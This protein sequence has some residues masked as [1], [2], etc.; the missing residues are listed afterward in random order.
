M[1]TFES[2]Y[3]SIGILLVPVPVTGIKLTFCIQ[4]MHK[5]VVEVVTKFRY[6][7]RAET[8]TRSE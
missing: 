1:L 2:L 6:I 3:A 8:R 5:I 7:I 4:S